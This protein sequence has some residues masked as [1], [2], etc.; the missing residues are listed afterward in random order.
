VPGW[1]HSYHNIYQHN[2]VSLQNRAD[3]GEKKSCKKFIFYQ[4]GTICQTFFKSGKLII[5]LYPFSSTG[6][7]AECIWFDDSGL[8]SVFKKCP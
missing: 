6:K 2:R 4:T 5:L 1:D 3:C 7:V 8:F